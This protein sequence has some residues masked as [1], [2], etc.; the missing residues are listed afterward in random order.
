MTPII[1]YKNFIKNATN[2]VDARLYLKNHILSQ[3]MTISKAALSLMC[4]RKTIRKLLKDTN[5]DYESKKAP[6]SCPHKLTKN[7]EQAIID[8]H[9]KHNYGPDMIKLNGQFNHSTSTIYRVLHD[10]NLI[11]LKMRKYKRKREANRTRIR[12]KAFEKWQ[13]DTKYL[14]DIPN[15]IGPIHQGTIPKY[16]YTLRDMVTGTTFLGYGLNERSVKDSC[17]FVALALYHMQLHGIDTHYVTIQSDNGSEFLGK[18]DKKE[19]YEIAKIV[20]DKFGGTFKTIPIKSPRFNSHVES[21]HGRIEHEFYDT[22]KMKNENDFL[23]GATAFETEWN[24]LRKALKRKKTPK[25]K[26]RE[27]S[28][29]LPECFYRFPVLVY[30]KITSQESNPIFSPG[31]YLPDEVNFVLLK[32]FQ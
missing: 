8:Y 7:I 4:S 12:L 1:S 28:F 25:M 21:F 23:K 13:L 6:H 27:Y 31:H 18:I 24:T 32:L 17:S 22:F 14:T 9:H 15:L 26:A 3:Q 11:G 20:E 10:H 30:D 5:L 19:K 16:E 2:K 29:L